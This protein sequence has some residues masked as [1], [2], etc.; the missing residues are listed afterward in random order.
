MKTGNLIIVFCFLISFHQGLKAQPVYVGVNGND[1]N[2]GTLE[3]PLKSLQVAVE[4]LEITN[5]SGSFESEA[6]RSSVNPLAKKSSLASS[7]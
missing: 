5:K 1:G 7:E 3:N 6:V 2:P 4:L